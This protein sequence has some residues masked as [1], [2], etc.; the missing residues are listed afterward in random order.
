MSGVV[1]RAVDS[2]TDSLEA[3]FFDRPAR[4]TREEPDAQEWAS[5][6]EDLEASRLAKRQARLAKYVTFAILGMSVPGVA[7]FLVYHKLI[8]PTP[9]PLV[10]QNGA[11]HELPAANEPEPLP[12]LAVIVPM[13]QTAPTRT[14]TVGSNAQ[15]MGPVSSPADPAD[16]AE[17]PDRA[18]ASPEKVAEQPGDQPKFQDQD[19]AGD[20]LGLASSQSS[21][22]AE[23]D[24][25]ENA[26]GNPPE[27]VPDDGTADKADVAA[28]NTPCSPASQQDR[29]MLG[30]DLKDSK[31]IGKLARRHLAKG[32][33]CGAER[34]AQLAVEADPKSSL[35]WIV[36]GAA[37]QD[38]RDH[39]GAREAY[40]RCAQQAVGRY[41]Q[42]CERLAR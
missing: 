5:D 26:P 32:D 41:V 40:R 13:P 8:M 3:G 18:P 22:G 35:G 31:E 12:E 23:V 9:V 10:S 39:E 29:E 27:V 14:G 15:P 28:E 1:P 6:W 19:M 17:S 11:G 30:A 20:R 33:A 4:K 34:L 2:E 38:R 21:R 42:E 36:L 16:P 24:R 37:R 7:G 25:A